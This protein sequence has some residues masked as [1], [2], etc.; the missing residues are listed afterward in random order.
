[1]QRTRYPERRRN[2]RLSLWT[3]LTVQR[4]LREG[5]TIDI[6]A[7]TCVVSAHGAVLLLDTPLIHGQKVQLIN[8]ITSEV[9]DC[10]V[11]SLGE[12]V[13]AASLESIS[14]PPNINFWHIVFPR[15]STRQAV[16]SA[17]TG[18][19]VLPGFRSDESR[20]F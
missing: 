1:M 11:T 7:S 12:R 5:E 8:D 3:P 13:T 4:S 16:R 17:K 20:Q 6:V 15:S 2:V 18:A 19:L 9:I 10:R 14:L